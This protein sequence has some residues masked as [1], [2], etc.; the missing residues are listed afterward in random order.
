MKTLSIALLLGVV[1]TK[2]LVEPQTIWDEASEE[3]AV[4]ICSD[5]WKR[6]DDPSNSFDVYAHFLTQNKMVFQD[7]QYEANMDS[8]YS[9]SNPPVGGQR[10]MDYYNNKIKGW[11]RPHQIYP[12]DG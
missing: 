2:N 6:W 5:H 11:M 4:D 3:V 9:V 7:K 10:R 12:E 8:I 1:S